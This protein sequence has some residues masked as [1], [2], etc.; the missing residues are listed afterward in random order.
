MKSLKFVLIATILACTAVSMAY[1]DGFKEKPKVIINITLNKAVLN[2]GLVAAMHAQL[3]PGFL[4]TNQPLYV[5]EV[6]YN[7]AIYRIMASRKLWIS[8]FLTEWENLQY[9]GYRAKSPR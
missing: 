3:N 2:P 8:F 1:A 6:H 9:E 4:N 7:G 5:A